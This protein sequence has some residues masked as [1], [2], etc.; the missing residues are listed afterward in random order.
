LRGRIKVG[1]ITRSIPPHPNPLPPG[2]RVGHLSPRQS[3]EVF[4]HILIKSKSG[5]MN[6]RD[7]LEIEREY[8]KAEKQFQEFCNKRKGVGGSK[9]TY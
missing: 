2:E 1:A 5:E 9:P 8:E 3:W 7:L 6:R 4:W